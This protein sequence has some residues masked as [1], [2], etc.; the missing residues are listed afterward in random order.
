[1][2]F[3]SILNGLENLEQ[4]DYAKVAGG[5]LAGIGAVAALPILGAFGTVS[6]LG[7]AVGIL[8]G[9]GTS[10]MFIEEEK[11]ER[12]Q[13][14]SDSK[15][16]SERMPS[17]GFLVR[18][19]LAESSKSL[20][21]YLAFI[22]MI[23]A[24]AAHSAFEEFEESPSGRNAVKGYLDDMLLCWAPENNNAELHQLFENPPSEQDVQALYDQ[25]IDGH[26][27]NR[28]TLADALEKTENLLIRKR[29]LQGFS[30]NL[31]P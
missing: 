25:V 3:E 27:L 10:L 23:Y 6:A 1:M 20:E 14:E 8:T 18:H 5:A 24:V 26:K 7:C 2:N 29:L 19:K 21:E 12:E 17:E 9:A 28:E 11:K 13:I 15:F 31:T 4:D 16:T 30:Q 22:K